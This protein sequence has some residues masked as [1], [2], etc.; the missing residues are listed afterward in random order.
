MTE[1]LTLGI[2]EPGTVGSIANARFYFAS[3]PFL[4][5]GTAKT[6]RRAWWYILQND[7]KNLAVF[8]LERQDFQHVLGM[9]GSDSGSKTGSKLLVLNH[10]YLKR[11]CH[12]ILLMKGI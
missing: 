3:N 6:L 4:I 12:E 9:M 10:F 2:K 5:T 8:K 1:G 11:L 7:A